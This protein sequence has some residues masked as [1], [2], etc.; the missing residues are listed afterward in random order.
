MWETVTLPLLARPEIGLPPDVQAR[1]LEPV[2]GN[3]EAKRRLRVQRHRLMTDAMFV[4]GLEKRRVKK[5]LPGEEFVKQKM[6]YV[7]Q[8]YEDLN[9]KVNHWKKIVESDKSARTVRKPRR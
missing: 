6:N 3:L 7:D 9:D 1:L 8:R 5:E 4:A 2:T